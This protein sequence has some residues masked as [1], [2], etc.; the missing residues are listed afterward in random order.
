MFKKKINWYPVIVL[1]DDCIAKLLIGFCWKFYSNEY[2]VYCA[3]FENILF[4]T[5]NFNVTS[6]T[7][8]ETLSETVSETIS[9]Y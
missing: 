7:L 3:A 1:C 2:S 8:S 6:Q 4:P 9:V 5:I